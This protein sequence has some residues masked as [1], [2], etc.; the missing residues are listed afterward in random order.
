MHMLDKLCTVRTRALCTVRR[1][2]R[3]VQ[4]VLNLVLYDYECIF[5]TTWVVLLLEH[6]REGRCHFAPLTSELA[7]RGVWQIVHQVQ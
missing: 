2:G 7:D 6:D 5:C 4:R 3:I 1:C